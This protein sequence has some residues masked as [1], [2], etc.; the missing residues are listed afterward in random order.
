ML[1]DHLGLNGTKITGLQISFLGSGHNLFRKRPKEKDRGYTYRS[2][3]RMNPMSTAL[4]DGIQR[5]EITSRVTLGVLALGSGVYTYLG[6]RELLN[7]DSSIV[8]PRPDRPAQRCFR[9]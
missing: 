3:Y 9:H 7:G 1:P 5:L 6:A 2:D 4:R 8:E